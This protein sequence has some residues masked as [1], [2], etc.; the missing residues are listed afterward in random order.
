[1]SADIERIKKAVASVP[2]L[3]TL[4]P[5]CIQHLEDIAQIGE[6]HEGERLFSEGDDPAY[7]YVLLSGR[8]AIEIHV[9]TRGSVRL[10]TVEPNDLFGWSGVTEHARYRT[11]TTVAIQDSTY[12]AFPSKRLMGL[13]AGDPQLGF[14]V[15]NR[16]ANAVA[17]RLQVTRLRLLDMFGHPRESEA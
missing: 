16:V 1:M 12:L 10:E 17:D 6:I 9:P 13:I 15:Y 7:L 5:S 2:W 3:N 8:L 14:C 4:H 11:G